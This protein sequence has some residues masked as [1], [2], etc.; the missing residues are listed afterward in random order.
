MKKL[1]LITVVLF[2]ANF[3]FSQYNME[4]GYIETISDNNAKASFTYKHL[5]IYPLTAGNKF[6]EAHKDLGKYTSL[7]ES[8]EQNNIKI[9]E[10]ESVNVNNQ[11]NNARIDDNNQ[12]QQV[13]VEQNNI[14]IQQNV[15]G[16]GG[17]QVNTLYIQNI[18]KDTIYIMAGEVVKG[19]KQDRILAQDMIL[20]PNGKKVDISVFCVEKNRWSY[21][22]SGKFDKYF[23]VSSNSIRQKV[24]QDQDQSAVWEEV[25]KTVR[26]NNTETNTGTYTSLVNSK[27]Y[28][29]ELSEYINF[30]MK[31]LKTKSN[32]IGFVGVSG[33]KI[34]GCDIFATPDL[35]NKQSETILNG[36]ITEAIIHGSTVNIKYD[37][38]KNYLE[39]ILT[40]QQDKQDNAINEKGGQY[41]YKNRKIHIT[42]F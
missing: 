35:F 33:D 7:K 16:G 9:T 19:G 6:K 5:R 38:V 13:N 4:E 25:G 24:I 31:S 21:G 36:Y 2:T 27:E 8:L 28:N 3:S 22:E 29:K 18:S 37:D 34:I 30:F 14:Q 42:T 10:T 20:P 40:V 12:E 32:C 1:L 23:S 39:E 17:A 11:R 41:E 26:K 15:S